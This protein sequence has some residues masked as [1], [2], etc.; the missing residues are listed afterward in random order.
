M[1]NMRDL[2]RS[3]RRKAR[4]E[5]KVQVV[6][7]IGE[8]DKPIFEPANKARKGLKVDKPVSE[9]EMDEYVDNQKY[10]ESEKRIR[11]FEKEQRLYKGKSEGQM[12]KDIARRRMAEQKGVEE[13]VPDNITYPRDIIGTRLKREKVNYTFDLYVLL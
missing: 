6:P 3:A 13:A 2:W 5:E 11:E 8:D 12:Q 7:K 4:K 9:M 10:L 1:P